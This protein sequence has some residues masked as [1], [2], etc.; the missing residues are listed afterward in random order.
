M[1]HGLLQ[2]PRGLVW[3]RLRAPHRRH[4]LDPRRGQRQRGGQGVVYRLLRSCLLLQAA[5]GADS[6]APPP[7]LFAAG[8]EEGER[9]WLKPHVHTPAARD[10][11][12]GA[13]RKR[14]LIYVYELPAIY[15]S[16]LLQVRSARGGR[17]GLPRPGQAR[18]L[19][20]AWAAAGVARASRARLPARPAPAAG[21]QRLR[22]PTPPAPA[23]CLQYR[24]DKHDCMTRQ[25]DEHNST[26][27]MDGWVYQPETGGRW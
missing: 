2:V 3:H 5:Q 27:Y 23:P 19:L 26:H 20:E 22:A 15:N 1:Q 6:Q 9:P 17:A 16:V 10:P 4:A 8:L 24:I 12:P 14:P 13:S 21:D 25:F 7:P 11:Q 18:G